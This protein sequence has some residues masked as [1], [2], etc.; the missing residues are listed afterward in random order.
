MLTLILTIVVLLW[1]GGEYEAVGREVDSFLAVADLQR[2]RVRE[3]IRV[4][5]LQGTLPLTTLT[6]IPEPFAI[7][8]ENRLI[9]G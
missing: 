8:Y 9:P 2:R 3:H 7:A 5:C 1:A 6:R 4:G